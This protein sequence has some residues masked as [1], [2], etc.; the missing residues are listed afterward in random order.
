MPCTLLVIKRKQKK[1]L[2]VTFFEVCCGRNKFSQL[3]LQ[4]CVKVPHRGRTQGCRCW[5]GH[6]SS[7]V[8]FF[9]LLISWRARTRVQEQSPTEGG[10]RVQDRP[11]NHVSSYMYY[12]LLI[13][14]SVTSCT[15]RALLLVVRNCLSHH[16]DTI[17]VD[18]SVRNT[19][20][21]LMLVR[22]APLYGYWYVIPSH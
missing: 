20:R 10:R 17:Y 22:I 12:L 13:D 19:S 9:L 2:C 6:A 4:H 14:V 21:A 7:L 11:L 8:R 16:T 5:P 18:A 3:L 15:P 1:K